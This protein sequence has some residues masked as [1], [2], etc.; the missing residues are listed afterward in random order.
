ME[1]VLLPAVERAAAGR[2]LGKL[3]DDRPGVTGILRVEGRPPLPDMELCYVPAGPFWMGEGEDEHLNECLDYPYWMGRYPVTNAQFRVFVDDPG[4]YQDNRWWTEAGLAWRKDRKGSREP[5]EPYNLPNHPVVRVTWYEALAHAR[6]LTERMGEWAEEPIEVRLP[7]EA[8]WEKAARGGLQ[9]PEK[10]VIICLGE[11]G[12]EAL[13]A[14]ADGP[15]ALR[16]NPSPNR[17]YPWQGEIEPNLANYAETSIGTT[18]AV[19]CFPGGAGPYG[20][21]ELSG[22][23]G[24]WTRSIYKDYPYRPKDGR[25]DLESEALRVLRG[26]SFL[27]GKHFARCAD[28]LH[29]LP[30]NRIF[31]LGFRVVV[32]SPIFPPLFSDTL[33]SG[34]LGGGLSDDGFAV[35]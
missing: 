10:R 4:G 23:V 7:S 6:W 35:C 31:D 22:N 15:V 28:R 11:G 14:V 1:Q 21:E 27:Y 33:Y 25:E 5:G 13:P 32:V 3:G 12:Q 19:G 17:R 26:G 24:E 29:Y 8:E 9:V 2:V 18:S 30:L 20:C 16:D 34:T